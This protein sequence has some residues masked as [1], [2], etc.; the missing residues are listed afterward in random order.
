MPEK[1]TPQGIDVAAASRVA[2]RVNLLDVRL[3]DLAASRHNVPISGDLTPDF[4]QSH[5]AIFH[6]AASIMVASQYKFTIRSG[7]ASVA[8][9]DATYHLSYV[10]EGE[11]E[12]TKDDLHH[13]SAAN[14]A[15]HS[16][17]FVRELLHGLTGRMGFPPYV[18]PVMSFL[19]S[20]RSPK[21]SARDKATKREPPVPKDTEG[22]KP[23]SEPPT[24]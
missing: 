3:A 6:E 5:R 1:I 9:V 17:P 24:V 8:D 22:S 7:D 11:E 12:I 4:S 14:G 16:W 10:V 19:P 23:P 21:A 18:L 2:R 13:F 20:Q 15:Y